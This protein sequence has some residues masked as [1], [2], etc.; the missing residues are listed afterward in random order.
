MSLPLVAPVFAAG[1][2]PLPPGMTEEDRANVLQAKK[3]QNYMTVGMESC[4]AKTTIAGVG[5]MH[6]LY[7]RLLY[8]F[9]IL[10]RF[11]YWWILLHDVFL[12]RVRGPPSPTKLEHHTKNKGN[13]QRDG[14]WYVE[15]WKGV[16]QGRGLVC[17]D[18][19]RHRIGS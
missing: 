19:V 13:I 12:F 10:S 11:C 3:Y 17:W 4:L 7:P 14:S 5:G 15:E 1:K 6:P 9:L 2:E 8:G 16:W 18:R